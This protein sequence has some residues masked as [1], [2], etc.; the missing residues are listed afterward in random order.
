MAVISWLH[1]S[2]ADVPADDGWLTPAEREVLAGLR[3]RQA[4]AGLA[5]RALHRQG[6]RRSVAQRRPRPGG[7][8]RRTERRTRCVLDGAPAAVSLS[9]SHR[10]GRALAMIGPAGAPIGCDL[11]VVEPRSDAFVSEWLALSEQALVRGAV[12]ERRALL[13]NLI[14]TAK[15]ASAKARAEGLRLNV[16]RAVVQAALETRPAEGG[17]RPL[18]VSWPAGQGADFGF[19]RAEPGWVMAVVG[20]TRPPRLISPVPPFQSA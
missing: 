11:E 18:R 8:A 19:W 1:R 17:W 7:G 15:E 9:L 16:R 5:A 13:A 4:A 2:L 6:S 12:A 20:L 3:N 10:A 14:W